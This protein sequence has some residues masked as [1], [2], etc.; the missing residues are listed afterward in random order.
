[1]RKSERLQVGKK[2]YCKWVRQRE[3]ER[4]RERERKRGR[5]PH[6]E[7]KRK[8]ESEISLL[9]FLPCCL[10]VLADSWMEFPC[11]SD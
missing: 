11:S 9:P 3:G 5:R 7:R 4:E 8:R 10:R 1:M 2:I 6:S